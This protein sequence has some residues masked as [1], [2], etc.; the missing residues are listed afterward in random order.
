MPVIL[1]YIII[2]STRPSLINIAHS[3]VIWLL[4]SV[5][6]LLTSVRVMI[7][8]VHEYSMATIR[9]RMSIRVVVALLGDLL[10]AAD[11]SGNTIIIC[12]FRV[13]IIFFILNL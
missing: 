9:V 3:L 12:I 6:L 7:V 13:W 4:V 8:A 5:R 10:I 2:I 11:L 1:G